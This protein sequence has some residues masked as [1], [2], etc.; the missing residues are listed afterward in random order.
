MKAEPKPRKD[1]RCVTCGQPKRRTRKPATGSKR[2][3]SGT[4]TR[5]DRK[6]WLV[7]LDRDPFCSRTCLESYAG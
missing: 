2:L 6:L 7:H 1:G 5:Q 4:Y 3:A